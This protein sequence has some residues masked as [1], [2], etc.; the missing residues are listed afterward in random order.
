VGGSA[1]PSSS[2]QRVRVEGGP[3]YYVHG[4]YEDVGPGTIA[5]WNPAADDEELTWQHNGMVYDL[6]AGGLH[7]ASNDLTRIA[8]SVR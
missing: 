7:L 5:A 3:A 2:A 1:V 8:E 4:A 6:T